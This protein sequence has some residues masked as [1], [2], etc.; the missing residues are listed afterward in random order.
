M[1]SI[2]TIGGPELQSRLELLKTFR[3]RNATR[4]AFRAGAAVVREGVRSEAPQRRRLLEPRRAGFGSLKQAVIS[5]GS[6][7]RGQK[8]EPAAFTR[9]NILKGRVRAPQ[10]HLVEFGMKA[11]RPKSKRFMSFIGEVGRGLG[12]RG[13]SLFARVFTKRTAAIRPNPFFERGTNK[14]S[15]EALSVT[16]AGVRRAIENLAEGKGAE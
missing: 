7:R 16:V 15:A 8:T 6:K 2:R 9:V 3:D 10:G 12:R 4:A 5:F 14:S 13:Q 1:P 11:R